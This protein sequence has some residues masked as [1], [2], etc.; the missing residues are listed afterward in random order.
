MRVR[1]LLLPGLTLGLAATMPGPATGQTPPTA[2]GQ[3]VTSGPTPDPSAFRFDPERQAVGTALH[4]VMTNLD[5]T[6]PEY[7]SA[8]LASSSRLE[9]CKFHPGPNRQGFVT[10]EMDW[11]TFSPRAMESWQVYPDGRSTLVA[12]LEHQR[13]EKVLKVDLVPAGVEGAEIPV[14]VLPFHVYAF[15]LL[16]LSVAMPHL[17][18]PTRPFAVGIVDPDTTGEGPVLQY[19]GNVT[20]SYVADEQRDGRDVRKYTVDG[21]G[22]D[23]R[24]GHLWVDAR[25]GHIVEI[26]MA[27]PANPDWQSFMFRLLRTETLD[28]D[29]WQSFM[30]AQ[31]A[32]PSGGP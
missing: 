5:G 19:K 21:P 32:G 15:D 31:F 8:Y 26:R 22:V 29:G 2:R 10:A 4:Y 6:R 17:R 9:V 11:T 27:R 3:G 16:S 23:G 14:P 20:V 7:I 24:G 12:R 18:N 28:P 1:H 13:D 25:H 30:S